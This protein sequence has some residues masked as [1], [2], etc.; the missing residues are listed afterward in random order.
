MSLLNPI[1]RTAT[2][3]GIERYKVEP[4]VIAADVYSQPPHTGRGGWSWYTGAAGWLYRAML[5]HLLGVQLAAGELRL[6]PRLPEAWERC[7]VELRRGS[8]MHRIRMTR[9]PSGQA[10]KVTLDGVEPAADEGGA[11]SVGV[12]R[13]VDDGRLHDVD[14]VIGRAAPRRQEEERGGNAEQP[15]EDPSHPSTIDQTRTR[16]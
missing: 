13:L 3:A 9:D 10:I 16:R 5:E 12:V 15:D 8:T 11:R 7:M 2:A 4:Y 6:A 14:V 1:H